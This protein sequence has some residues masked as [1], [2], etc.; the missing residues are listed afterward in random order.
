[1]SVDFLSLDGAVQSDRF[2]PKRRSPMERQSRA[3][4]GRFE[5]R[6]GWVLPVAYASPEHEAETL[7]RTAGWV[8]MSHLA[9][10]ELQAAPEDLKTIVSSGASGPVELGSAHRTPGTWWSPLAPS[11]VLVICEPS[12]RT[13]V[14]GLLEDA[15]GTSGAPASLVDVSATFAALTVVGPSAREV[16]AR[17]CAIDLRPQVTPVGAVRPGS[18]ARQPGIVICEGDQRFLMLF[19]WAVGEYVWSQVEEAGRRLGGAPVGVDALA[20]L[21]AQVE[22]A[23]L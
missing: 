3:V 2:S 19:G 12:T 7:R 5:V 14:H 15:I 11:R 16:L 6:D 20:S 21:D 23:R 18:V 8:D 22:E 17:F 10:L 4:G 13:T 9:K 1:V